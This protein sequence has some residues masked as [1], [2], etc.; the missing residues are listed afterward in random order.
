[1]TE[2]ALVLF[3]GGQNSAICLPWALY[4]FHAY[5]GGGT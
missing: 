4:R 2:K 5:A 1:M 3:S